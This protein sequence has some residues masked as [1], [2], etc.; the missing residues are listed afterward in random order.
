MSL[1][2][3]ESRA[4][5]SLFVFHISDIVA[6]FLVYVDDIIITGSSPEFVRS[7]FVSLSSE[8]AVKDLSELR[9]FLGIHVDR[10]GDGSLFLSPYQYVQN[11][12]ELVDLTNLRPTSTPK[13]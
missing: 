3:K 8:F 12:L 11:L 1:G 4:D 13:E 10:K 9:Q 5:E 7:V 2:F 6:Y